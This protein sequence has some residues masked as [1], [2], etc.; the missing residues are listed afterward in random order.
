VTAFFMKQKMEEEPDKW[1][2]NSI[3]W[4]V[5]FANVM[6]LRDRLSHS[7]GFLPETWAYMMKQF[8]P[9]VILILFVNLAAS[10][11]DD[12]ETLFGNY[13]GYRAWPFQYI[14]YG[15][16]VFAG[17]LF[18]IGL[19]FPDVYNGLTLVDTKTLIA[20]A[21]LQTMEDDKLKNMK[22]DESDESPEDAPKGEEVNA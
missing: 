2:W 16:V 9:H 7:I 21:E 17:F 14:G 1:T 5:S 8:I 4:E 13:G 12:G 15:T 6:H 3:I 10:Q 20:E 18:L 19:V 11:T 22:G